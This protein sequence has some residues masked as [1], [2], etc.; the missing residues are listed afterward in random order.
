MNLVDTGL[1]A[2]ARPDLA[3]PDAGLVLA[4][5]WHTAG[6]EQQRR[7]MSGVMDAWEG[8]RLPA[9]Y[10]AR[11]CLEGSD[12][13][14][15]LNVAQWTSSGAH[16]AFAADPGNQRT[17]GGA[18]RAL[19]TADPPGRHIPWRVVRRREGTAG[20]LTVR[21]YDTGDAGAGRSLAD[22]LAARPAGAESP[23]PVVEHFSV[24]EDGRRLLVLAGFTD[25]PGGAGLWFR[26]FRGLVRAAGRSAS[27]ASPA[28]P[29]GQEGRA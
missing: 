16:R 18:I 9:A 6:P 4:S 22:E 3:R 8:T 14:T 24:A 21:W 25:E 23:A 2:E 13:R 26:P 15:V 28:A 17:L 20:F 29:P 12:G 10:L 11:H 27:G 1:R 5:L 19:Y 7:V